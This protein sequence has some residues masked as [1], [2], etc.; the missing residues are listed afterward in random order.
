VDG[1]NFRDAE[2]ILEA[3]EERLI[4]I[5]RVAADESTFD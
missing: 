4:A 2:Q 1:S 5:L 3:L